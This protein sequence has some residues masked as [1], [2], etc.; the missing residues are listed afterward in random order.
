MSL[1]AT[2]PNEIAFHHL[3]WAGFRAPWQN[4]NS[5]LVCIKA[6]C[7]S[8]YRRIK[9]QCCMMTLRDWKV[10]KEFE[11]LEIVRHCDNTPSHTRRYRIPHQWL[12]IDEHV[13]K[14]NIEDGFCFSY[15]LQ[16]ALWKSVISG[17]YLLSACL[18][19]T[20][21]RNMDERQ[22]S[23]KYWHRHRKIQADHPNPQ[24]STSHA[25]KRKKLKHDFL[26]LVTHESYRRYKC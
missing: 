12:K 26:L 2:H 21:R 13:G 4:T 25:R 1:T 22:K 9:H 17:S 19:C 14:S 5:A 20:L 8:S 3:F 15:F 16:S 23:R 24:P 10:W 18:A 6:R 11:W 7:I